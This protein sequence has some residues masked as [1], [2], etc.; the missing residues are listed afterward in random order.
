MFNLKIALKVVVFFLLVVFASVTVDAQTKRRPI[1]VAVVVEPGVHAMALEKT[2]TTPLMNA[3]NSSGFHVVDRKMAEKDRRWQVRGLRTDDDSTVALCDRLNADCIVFLRVASVKDGRAGMGYSSEL[4]LV[5]SLASRDEGVV[6]Y[7]NSTDLKGRSS[8]SIALAQRNALQGKPMVAR[9]TTSIIESLKSHRDKVAKLGR[10]FSIQLSIPHRENTARV[11]ARFLELVQ[12]IEAGKNKVEFERTGIANLGVLGKVVGMETKGR[13]HRTRSEIAQKLLPAMNDLIQEVFGDGH[14]PV[15]QTAGNV[16]A[17]VVYPKTPKAVS[18]AKVNLAETPA[19]LEDFKK[20][21][22]SG[23]IE[24][25]S[26]NSSKGVTRGTGFLI[27]EDGFAITNQHSVDGL[28]SVVHVRFSDNTQRQCKVVAIDTTRELALLRI[29][30]PIEGGYIFKL[31]REKPTLLR[32]RIGLI[33][34]PNGSSWAVSTGRMFDDARELASVVYEIANKKGNTGSPVVLLDI[35]GF[36]VVAIHMT[37]NVKG[38][39]V[40]LGGASDPM[41]NSD[42]PPGYSP[43]GYGRGCSASAIISFLC[44]HKIKIR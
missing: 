15:L 11:Q 39:S 7:R 8:R 5:C 37:T 33:G 27:S 26:S 40:S 17:F 41:P 2:V 35:P 38:S 36:P 24:I 6:L 42:S 30:D 3:L 28:T 10:T 19:S 16:I 43:A 12:A 25:V 20:Q 21:C 13:F 4:N 9:F 18:A 44:A 23:I 32:P 14:S 31:A 22:K 29:L 34:D 1:S